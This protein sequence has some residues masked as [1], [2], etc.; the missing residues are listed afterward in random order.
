MSTEVRVPTTGNAGEDAVLVEWRVAVGDGVQPDTV[1]A[2][3]ETAKTTMDVVA[4][5]AGVVLRLL[6]QPGDEV[7]EFGVIA[8]IGAAGVEDAGEV[9]TA[10][11]HEVVADRV[12]ISPRARIMA[13]RRGLDVGRISGSGPNGRILIA[14]VKRAA[15]EVH[16]PKPQSEPT[17][18]PK[19]AATETRGERIALR[20][21]RKVTAQRLSAAVND[22]APVTLQRSAPADVLL[23]FASRLKEAPGPRIGV[24]E[25]VM[26]AVATTLARHPQAN[27]HFS[28]DGI[29]QFSDVHL[30]FAVDNGRALL[31]PVVQHAHRKSLR[32]FATESRRLSD[33][34]LQDRVTP[35]HMEGATFTVTNLGPFG[36]EWFTPIVS[37]PQVCILGVG[38]VQRREGTSHLPL[39]LTFDHRALDGAA[40]AQCLQDIASAIASID[41]VAALTETDPSN[42]A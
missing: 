26:F 40:A 35:E 28:W 29:T 34:A 12:S 37:T 7:P 42:H 23:N 38:A 41:V 1:L 39:S 31:V 20:G 33:L 4:P 32:A 18:P 22:V 13:E 3:V 21:A 8:E 16:S 14:D 11:V 9:E 2:I 17:G 24:N 10:T 15:E 19:P 30:G 27:A 36:V 25:L 6:A 5:V